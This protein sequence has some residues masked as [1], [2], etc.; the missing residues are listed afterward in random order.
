[1]A[2]AK[3]TKSSG[4]D[5][6]VAKDG[7]AFYYHGKVMKS[8]GQVLLV[9]TANDRTL[10]VYKNQK[11][12]DR[13]KH[14]CKFRIGYGDDISPLE[15]TFQD[16]QW[17]F[18]IVDKTQQDQCFSVPDAQ[19]LTEWLGA[20]SSHS[21]TGALQK[22]RDQQD[23]DAQAAGQAAAEARELARIKAMYQPPVL[24]L[25]DQKAFRGV[26]F[27]DL[28][29]FGT[30]LSLQM[31]FIR[32]ARLDVARFTPYQVATSKAA[33]M[34]GTPRS[35]Q[36]AALL[37][38]IADRAHGWAEVAAVLGTTYHG[39]DG[40][41]GRDG[42]DGARGANGTPGASS[43]GYH[44]GNGGPGWPGEHGT[45]GEP[46]ERGENGHNA[47]SYE[48]FFQGFAGNV[49]TT[50]RTGGQFNLGARGVLLLDAKGGDGG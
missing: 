31:W 28:P 33:D 13:G 4:R 34:P 6:N 17:V 44:G 3:S 23:A 22:F 30:G 39:K 25:N 5:S 27:R 21:L 29:T 16:R 43:R 47:T 20:P 48:I 19:V 35:Q 36:D 10:R 15:G 32:A 26:P 49:L 41:P 50:A 24:N 14:K 37:D 1:M 38:S 46:G 42:H 45:D 12:L 2:P 18:K 7:S 9:L 40:R 8:W 11:K